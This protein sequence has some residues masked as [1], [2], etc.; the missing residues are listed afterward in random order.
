MLKAQKKLSKR[1]LKQDALLMTVAKAT[2]FYEQHKKNIGMVVG[3]LAA[4]IIGSY[5]YAKNQADNNE[6]ATTALGKVFPYFD[7]GQY[8][9]A[10]EGVP[11]RNIMG[12]KAIVENYGS[13]KTGN[14]AKLYLA[15]AY[16][17]L[18]NYN[19]A[20]ALFDDF[21]PNDPLTAVARLAGMAGCHEARGEYEKAAEYFEKAA[22]SYPK[23]IDAAEHLNSAASNYALAGKRER[24]L[25][26]YKKLK[27]DYPT[28]SYG[29]DADRYIAQLSAT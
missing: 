23:D 28:S 20:L 21:S 24:A 11:E 6:K 12:L 15:S 7:G 13:T 22:L 14:L 16:F 9:I 3:V 26:L 19:E 17:E 25:E 1:E 10:I 4:I 8:K 2:T 27:K 29:R 18:G 5:I